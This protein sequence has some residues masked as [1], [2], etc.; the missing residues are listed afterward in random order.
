MSEEDGLEQVC[1][2]CGLCCKIFGDRISPT[3]TNLYQWMESGRTDILRHFFAHLEDGRSVNC[4]N[5]AAEDLGSLLAVEMR[6]P[7]SGEYPP[8]CP[9]LWRIS[10]HTYVCRIHTQKPEMCCHYQPWIWGET[11]FNRCKALKNRHW[12][13]PRAPGDR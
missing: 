8:V 4:V 9:F 2:L 13:S 12:P 11:Y 1:E 5:L 3:S 6:D 10:K 7:D